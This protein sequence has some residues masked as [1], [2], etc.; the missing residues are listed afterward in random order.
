MYSSRLTPLIHQYVYYTA[1][2]FPFEWRLVVVCFSNDVT[3]T[4][5]LCCELPDASRAQPI[6]TQEATYTQLHGDGFVVA[7]AVFVGEL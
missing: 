4:S 3:A 7:V 1:L 2:L 5:R 6:T